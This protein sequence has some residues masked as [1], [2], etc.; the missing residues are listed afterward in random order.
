MVVPPLTCSSQT[1]GFPPREC[2]RHA[3]GR[4][5]DAVDLW[6]SILNERKVVALKVGKTSLQKIWGKILKV[7]KG[8]PGSRAGSASWLPSG[9]LHPVKL[10]ISVIWSAGSSVFDVEN[11]SLIEARGKCRGLLQTTQPETAK[12]RFNC[13]FKYIDISSSLSKKENPKNLKIP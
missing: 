10:F 6:A 2:G 1:G 12:F 9:R 13:V 3:G 11:M 5:G 7:E 8:R 4:L